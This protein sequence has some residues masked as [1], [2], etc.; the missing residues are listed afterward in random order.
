MSQNL[1]RT[2]FKVGKI[3]SQKI[4]SKTKEAVENFQVRKQKM[5][6]NKEI[7]AQ[8]TWNNLERKFKQLDQRHAFASI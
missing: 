3:I 7:A 6:L 2:G 5:E 4:S 1:L 8:V